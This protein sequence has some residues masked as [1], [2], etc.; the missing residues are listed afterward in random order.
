MCGINGILRF[1]QAKV[2][3]SQLLKMR[4][5][6]EHRGPDDAGFYLKDHIGLGIAVCLLL[7]PVPLVINPFFLKTSAM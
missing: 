1:S 3:E 4:D 5:A 6:L 7:T 2:E